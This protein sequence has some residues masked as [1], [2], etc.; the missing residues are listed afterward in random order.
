MTSSRLEM[1]SSVCPVP[2]AQLHAR[3]RPE[4]RE[5]GAFATAGL[6]G[7][8]RRLWS[9]IG[10]SDTWLGRE[11]GL[12][13][14][15]LPEDSYSTMRDPS[16]VD[17]SRG[18][19]G[20]G[21]ARR[22]KAGPKWWLPRLAREEG[23]WSTLESTRP[24]RSRH[25]LFPGSRLATVP[26]T[27]VQLAIPT[28]QPKPATLCSREHIRA[29]FQQYQ[30]NVR[31]TMEAERAAKQARLS[32][33][34]Q[35]QSRERIHIM[36]HAAR[37]PA[38]AGLPVLGGVRSDAVATAAAA[39]ATAGA[40]AASGQAPMLGGETGQS[41]TQTGTSA[42]AAASSGSGKGPAKG[43][44][45]GRGRGKAASSSDTAAGAAPGGGTTLG[46]K[47]GRSKS[48]GKTNDGRSHAGSEDSQAGASGGAGT[49][50]G[51]DSAKGKTANPKGSKRRRKGSTGAAAATT[52][53]SAASS[54]RPQ[55]LKL[56]LPG[57]QGGAVPAA[58]TSASATAATPAFG[59]AGSETP[60]G[61]TPRPGNTSISGLLTMV[62]AFQYRRQPLRL[63]VPPFPLPGVLRVLGTAAGGS[64]ATLAGYP[65]FAAP[66]SSLAATGKGKKK[67]TSKKAKDGHAFAGPLQLDRFGRV[68]VRAG[69]L[70]KMAKQAEYSGNYPLSSTG[71]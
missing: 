58:L 41:A 37:L 31:K 51:A 15:D 48:T 19:A 4:T 60:S 54:G 26:D 64:M 29:L 9:T 70:A 50:A 10:G 14:W 38:G 43:R 35:R 8:C 53:A 45:R 24:T 32:A 65:W 22:K 13:G 11:I 18:S 42:G 56:K 1:L 34:L 61:M 66:D 63:P 16:H 12:S 55:P 46:K 39:A 52:D 6:L 2:P 71:G 17:A 62:R 59:G 5:A 40:H 44:G 69:A 7:L 28:A 23:M 20:S 21:G 68:I 67:T 36:S 25:A 3:S 30:D 33:E 47:R 27:A 49:A 57:T